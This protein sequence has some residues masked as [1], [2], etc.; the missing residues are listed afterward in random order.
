[1]LLLLGNWLLLPEL[2][3]FGPLLVLAIIALP[4]VL[5]SVVEL[6]RQPALRKWMEVLTLELQKVCGGRAAEADQLLE[7]G[8]IPRSS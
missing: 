1:M 2:G 7:D 6:F 3:G 4:G 5:S 8:R